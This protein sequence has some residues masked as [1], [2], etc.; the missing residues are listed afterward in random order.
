MVLRTQ[1]E[2]PVKKIL[3][4]TVVRIPTLNVIILS[5]VLHLYGNVCGVQVLVMSQVRWSGRVAAKLLYNE[6][7][8][9][10]IVWPACTFDLIG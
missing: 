1:R 4:M 2:L 9:S 3:I 10:S 5:E 6:I 7:V 8:I